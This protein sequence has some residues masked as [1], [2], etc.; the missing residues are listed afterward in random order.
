MSAVPILS[1]NRLNILKLI[2][3]DKRL[4]QLLRGAPGGAM[5]IPKATA[6]T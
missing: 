3:L 4:F 1:K 5:I 6:G 2:S